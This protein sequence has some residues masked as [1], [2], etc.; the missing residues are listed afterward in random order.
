MTDDLLEIKKAL[1]KKLKKDR[2]EHTIGVM[3]TSASLAMRYQE[4]L[5]AALTVGLLHD[6]GKYCSSEEQI[7]LCEKKG[8]QL[9]ES[10]LQMPALVHAKLGAYLAEHNYGI[11]DRR[12][13]DA[14]LWHTTGHPDMTMLEKIVYIADYIEPN[15]KM[16][17]GLT[18]IRDLV[19]QDIDQAI[20]LCSKN[21]VEYLQASGK[22][23]DPMSI[24]TYKFYAGK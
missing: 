20:C 4:D 24:E 2:Y 23:V 13:L 11:Q 8:I 19:F 7:A 14:I 15:R 3:Y 18:E 10:E 1:S 21:T 22:P 12:V 9:T 16:I 6:C 5:Q 17:P